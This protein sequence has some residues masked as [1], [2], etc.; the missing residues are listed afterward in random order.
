[1]GYRTIVVG[2]DGS[3]TANAAQRAAVTMAKRT[4]ARVVLV[5]GWDP[6]RTNRPLAEQTLRRAEALSE[7][8]ALDAMEILVPVVLV[9]SPETRARMSDN[10]YFTS[11]I[12]STSGRR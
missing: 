6:A 11:F 10:S 7:R 4:K 1:M 2:T 8:E 5:C 3:V 12:S 9:A